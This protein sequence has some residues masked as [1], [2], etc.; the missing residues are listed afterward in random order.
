MLSETRPR[1][2]EPDG[3]EISGDD[4][5]IWALFRD[6]ES[7]LEKVWTLGDWIAG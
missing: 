5:D 1:A 7:L 2:F 3:S 4:G 6:A